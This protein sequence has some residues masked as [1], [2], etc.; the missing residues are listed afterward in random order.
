MP[1]YGN[2]SGIGVQTN[3][4]FTLFGKEFVVLEHMPALAASSRSLMY[5]DMQAAYAIAEKPTQ[6]ILRNP[7]RAD[8]KVSFQGRK[9]VGGDVKAFDALVMVTTSA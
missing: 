6:T 7:F 3:S 1:I 2:Q 4:G 5:G 8:N 9:R